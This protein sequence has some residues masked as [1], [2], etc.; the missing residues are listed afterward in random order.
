MSQIRRRVDS[1]D[2]LAGS[3]QYMLEL[4]ETVAGA[5]FFGPVILGQP[6][7]VDRRTR[8]AAIGV[9]GTIGDLGSARFL[10]R[11]TAAI[12]SLAS[13]GTA[14][15]GALAARL[16]EIIDR[17]SRR[18]TSD[19]L[20]E[21]VIGLVEAVNAFEGAYVTQEMIDALLTIADSNYSRS[22]RMAALSALRD[23]GSSREP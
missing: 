3:Y 19:S 12:N 15:D 9:L 6:L 2:N 11:L 21:S 20:A 13:L 14:L 10:A 8:E 23:L 4:C 5:P 18:E 22:T 1:R 7:P 17:D 16:L